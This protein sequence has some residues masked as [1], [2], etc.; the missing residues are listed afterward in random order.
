VVKGK[1]LSRNP[2]KAANSLVALV[3]QIA[4]GHHGISPKIVDIEFKLFYCDLLV[5]VCRIYP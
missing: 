3:I 4:N 1:L 5:I 2:K